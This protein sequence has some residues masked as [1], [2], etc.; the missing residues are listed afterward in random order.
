MHQFSCLESLTFDCAFARL[1]CLLRQITENIIPRPGH[2]QVLL[3]LTISGKQASGLQVN[4]VSD[5]QL[6]NGEYRCY[7]PPVKKVII[8]AEVSEKERLFIQGLDLG[9]IK[10]WHL[11]E[12]SIENGKIQHRYRLV[13][14]D[15]TIVAHRLV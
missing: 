2:P 10:L 1:A 6:A 14:K 4:L 12:K 8:T 7:M 5:A 15:F 9:I 3:K 11:G 13:E